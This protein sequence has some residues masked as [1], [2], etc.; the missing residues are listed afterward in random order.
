MFESVEAEVVGSG[1]ALVT[2]HA[3]ER[4]LPR[5]SPVVPRQ[6][7]GAAKRPIAFLPG[8]LKRLLASVDP[9]VSLEV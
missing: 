3:L 6:L 1:E 2:L 9:L 5:V 7:V 8:T 4:L